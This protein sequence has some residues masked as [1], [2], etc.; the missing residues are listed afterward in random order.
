MFQ[1]IPKDLRQRQRSAGRIADLQH[2]FPAMVGAP[3]EAHAVL[4]ANQR[5]QLQAAHS[6]PHPVTQRP[7]TSKLS[8]QTLAQPPLRQHNPILAELGWWA[9]PSASPPPLPIERHQRCDLNCRSHCARARHNK[10][11]C[12]AQL[13]GVLGVST[14]TP[15]P[16]F[17]ANNLPISC[18]WRGCRCSL[19]IQSQRVLDLVSG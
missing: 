17:M 16:H 8:P 11:E 6:H 7:T 12:T 19:Q 9:V 2:N 10:P 14:M 15:A 3:V 13:H 1:K 18:S 5:P 4:L